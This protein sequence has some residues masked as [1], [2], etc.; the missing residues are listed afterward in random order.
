MICEFEV[1][2]DPVAKGRPRF[3]RTGFA[4][5]PQKTARYENLVRLAY[6]GKYPDRNPSESAVSLSMVST[7]PIPV[8][9]PKKKKLLALLEKIFKKS[10]PDLDNLIKSVCDGLNEV[11]W[12]DDAQIFE[13]YAR[14]KYGE[15]PRTEVKIDF[16]EEDPE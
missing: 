16:V 13:L 3:T 12:K 6:A 9:W 4:Y 10:R 8:S 1:P 7:F 15:V 5:T 14:K 11:A 2:G